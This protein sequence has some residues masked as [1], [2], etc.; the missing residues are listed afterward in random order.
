MEERSAVQ[1]QKQE[2]A[3]ARPVK[4]I[5]SSASGPNGHGVQKIAMAALGNANGL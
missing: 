1:L 3:M 5:V 4:Q 2:G